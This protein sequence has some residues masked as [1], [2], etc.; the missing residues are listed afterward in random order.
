MYLI[1]VMLLRSPMTNFQMTVR[2]DCAVSAR[3]LLPQPVKALA[4]RLPVGGGGLGTGQL[5]SFEQ[6][7][8]IVQLLSHV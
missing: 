1:K 3:C 5:L 7:P 4:H 8:L 6:S 2:A